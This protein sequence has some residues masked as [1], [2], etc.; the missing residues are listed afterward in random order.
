[1]ANQFLK[2]ETIAATALGLL[3]RELVLANLVWNNA[4][5]D[6]TGAKND[7][8]TIRIPAVLDAREQEWRANAPADIVLDSLTESSI[9]VK[10][11]KDIYSAVQVTDEELTLDIKDFG[12]QVL[13]P[14]VNAVARAIDNGVA[15]LVEGATYTNTITIDPKDPWSGV[16]DARA[17]L[18]RQNVDFKD[19]TLLVGSDVETNILKSDRLSKVDQSGDDSALRDAT[20][21]KLAGFNVVTSNAIDPTTAYAFVPSAFVLAT[22]APAIPGGVAFGASQSYNGLSMRWIKDYDSNKLRDRSIVNIYAGFNVMTDPLRTG[23]PADKGKT[24]LLR[25]VKLTLP[26]A[27]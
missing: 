15:A 24:A 11:N 25:A 6:F 23:K 22:R 9:D 8:V 17:V 14:Q 18:N 16:I 1:M 10:L 7:S 21:G 4:G 27:P 13:A 26:K 19:R 20:V 2:A 12:S 5:F 3:E